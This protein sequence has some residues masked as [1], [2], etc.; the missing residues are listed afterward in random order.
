MSTSIHN[1]NAAPCRHRGAAKPEIVEQL[2]SLLSTTLAL[3][4]KYLESHGLSPEEYASALPTAIERLRGSMAASNQ[5]RRDFVAE[6]VKHL[7]DARVVLRYQKPRYGADTVYRLFLADGSQVGLI[8]KGCPDGRHSSVAWSRPEWA[9]ELYLWWVCSSKNLEPGEH[10][11]KGV[12][13]VRGKVS[14]PDSDQLDGLIFYNQL[15][16]TPDRPCP[17]LEHA[18]E[19]NGIKL[20]PPCIYVF[21][22]W[23]SDATTLNWHGEQSRSFPSQMLKAFGIAESQVINFTSFVGFRLA[24]GSVTTTEISNRF[25]PFK[26][27][28]TRG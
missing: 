25:G 12:S 26:K 9:N 5:E 14:S 2:I 17:K 4:V 23:E 19:R 20:P 24:G 15:C 6:V 27:T 8:Q 21:P 3:D 28:T 1:A 10:V 16:G 11:W 18:I 13:R 7:V 22:R